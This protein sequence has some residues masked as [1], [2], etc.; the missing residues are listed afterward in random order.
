[1]NGRLSAAGSITNHSDRVAGAVA[2]NVHTSQ[3]TKAMLQSSMPT[4]TSASFFTICV[5]CTLLS[6]GCAF[7][8]N[9]WSKS[10]L[11]TSTLPTQTA[12]NLNTPKPDCGAPNPQTTPKELTAFPVAPQATTNQALANNGTLQQQPMVQQQPMQ[13]QPMQQQPMQQQPM[14]QQPMQQQAMQQQPMQQQPMVQQQP[15]QQQPMQPLTQPMAQTS[16]VGTATQGQMLS[17]QPQP[18]PSQTTQPMTTEMVSSPQPDEMLDPYA[19]RLPAAMISP[20]PNHPKEASRAD[21]TAT[22]ASV[23]RAQ[24]RSGSATI[25]NCPP[26]MVPN[27]SSMADIVSPPEKLAECEKQVFEMNQKLNA[28]QFDTMKA[29]LTMEQMAEQQRQ[30]MIDNERLRRRAEMADQRYL[31]ELDSLSEIV[32]E[33]V[34]Q[35]GS[36]NTSTSARKPSRGAN[37][38]R[39]VPQS[40]TGQSL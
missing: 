38:L 32:G 20:A 26:G 27:Y 16:V 6:T 37:P 10:N 11:Q 9:L 34:S 40:A 3:R 5:L 12:S 24:A 25:P 2:D 28:L 17:A 35:A 29:S 33:V 13:Q 7:S 30:L 23:L 22:P 8:K 4:K 39:S 1:M 21:M 15:M 36:G 19:A 31:E 18:I 14:Q